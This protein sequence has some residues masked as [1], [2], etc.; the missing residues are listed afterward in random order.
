MTTKYQTI[1]SLDTA[2]TPLASL[3]L[4]SNTS[5]SFV[6]EAHGY[7]AGSCGVVRIV[8][9]AKNI[10]GAATVLGTT[11]TVYADAAGATW[12]GSA[13]PSGG[14]LVMNVQGGVGQT[15]SWTLARADFA[16]IPAPPPGEW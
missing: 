1:T 13:T 14:N 6:L 9:A 11:V 3:P 15:V 4:A 2:I 5:Q 10:S 16:A 8:G 7:L 12:T